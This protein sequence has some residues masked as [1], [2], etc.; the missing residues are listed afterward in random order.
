MIKGFL[1]GFVKPPCNQRAGECVHVWMRRPLVWL[2][3]V[4]LFF[5]GI[6]ALFIFFHDAFTGN[7]AAKAAAALQAIFAYGAIFPAG[8]VLIVA[9]QSEARAVASEAETERVRQAAL[10]QAA[11]TYELAQATREQ[12]QLM[13]AQEER[14][15]APNLVLVHVAGIGTDAKFA[16][17]NLGMQTMF[18]QEVMML[19]EENKPTLV[20]VKR[21][22]K[23][24]PGRP[25]STTVLLP[26]GSTPAIIENFTQEEREVD[27]H[28]NRYITVLKHQAITVIVSFLHAPTGNKVLNKAFHITYPPTEIP[29]APSV[30][31]III[32]S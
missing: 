3:L 32:Q 7:D 16:L 17:V 22:N 20:N 23:F 1:P 12:A 2:V 31:E 6:V 19:D 18:I 28:L 21:K 10:Q 9:L 13:R 4:L 26:G 30:A 11:A 14:G 29:T 27:D 8:A 25:L 24:T 5:V 15:T